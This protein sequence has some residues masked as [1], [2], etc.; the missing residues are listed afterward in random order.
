MNRNATEILES[1]VRGKDNDEYVI[2]EK[3]YNENAKVIF[4]INSNN[5]SFPDEIQGNKE[6]ARVLSKDFN[7]NYNSVRTYYLSKPSTDYESIKRQNW[8]VVMR[9]KKTD[10]TRVGTGYYDWKFSNDD[11]L[12]KILIHKIYIH[13]MVELVDGEM[14]ELSRIQNSLT[15][16]WVDKEQVYETLKSNVALEEVSNYLSKNFG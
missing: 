9:D 3:I 14:A 13:C 10:K 8:L 7:K 6:I 4:E 12:L 16:P 15:Y 11:G 5:I 2:L 1:Y